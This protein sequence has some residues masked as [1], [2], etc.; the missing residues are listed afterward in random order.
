MGQLNIVWVM[1]G[2]AEDQLVEKR[3][4]KVGLVKEGGMIEVISGLK[5]GEFLFQ[6]P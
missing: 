1:Q 2:T 3:F 6:K 4:I 5:E